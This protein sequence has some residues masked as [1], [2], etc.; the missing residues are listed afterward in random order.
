MSGPIAQYWASLGFRIDRKEIRKVDNELKRIE[1]RIKKFGKGFSKN[2]NLKFNV[3]SFVVDQRKLNI[4][5]G[6]ALD[7][8]SMSVVFEISRFSVN[9]R[10][11]QAALLRAGRAM[12]P[13]VQQ[14]AK[15]GVTQQPV[16]QGRSQASYSRANFLHAGGSA[17]ALARYGVGSLPFVG[18]VY[19]LAQAN[20]IGQE[21]QKNDIALKAVA[22]ADAA[23]YQEFLNNLGNRMGMTTR[24]LQPG[25]TQYLANAQGT[26]LEP[27]I[28]RDF[29]SFV[30]YGAVMGLGPE[31][32]KGSLKAIT[33]MV[34]KQQIYAEEL[35]GQLAER[36]PAAVRLMADAVTGGDTK[37][38]IKMME[39]G[40]LDP[41]TA[42][43]LFF[44]QMRQRSESFLPEYFKSSRFA[45]GRMDKAFEDQMKVFGKSGGDQ[46]F[47]NFFNNMT[48][49]FKTSEPLVKAL[50][51]TFEDLTKALQA[52]VYLFGKMTDVLKFM[53][54]E[55]GIAEKNFTNLALVGGLMMTKWGKVATMFSTMLIVLEDIAMG[56]SGE[57]D[58]FTGR[59]IKWMD[60]SGMTMGPFEKGLLGVSAA[61][62]TIATALK[63]ISAATSLPGISDVFGGG[64]GKA[65]KAGKGG[66]WLLKLAPFALAG[67]VAGGVALGGYS[68]MEPTISARNT[69]AERWNDPMSP[70]YNNSERQRQAQ[71]DI[72]NPNSEF[73]NNLSLWEQ[74]F[75]QRGQQETFM[76]MM[77]NQSKYGT[78]LPGVTPITT[79]VEAGAI[80]INTA[81]TDAEG[82]AKE[83]EPHIKRIFDV[84]HE[85]KIGA[86]LLM[87]P[88][89][90]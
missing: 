9:Q 68:L 32:M 83:L 33:Q 38:L 79:N 7:K 81:A 40:E 26:A 61:M 77:N 90:E 66:G 5:L 41:N 14:P 2:L 15:Q 65:G 85:E 64:G 31:E 58:S 13:V 63:A 78:S 35:K 54:A 25:F 8:A 69:V 56:V 50:A 71:M 88:Q 76:T 24:S 29:S 59:F 4:S 48:T 47:T 49:L 37:A 55:T 34:S 18:G 52:P 10:N 43:P 82:I 80:V 74:R 3:D 53:S 16:Q 22:G 60:E 51:G 42:L 57:G 45:Q 67:G 70:L 6:N 30:Q 84:K 36:M 72:R 87:Y 1:Q 75:S 46:G 21:L 89:A 20:Q 17:G 19:G 73:F 44:E 28:Q 62:L 11:M 23:K 39:R 27:T 86:A 12:S